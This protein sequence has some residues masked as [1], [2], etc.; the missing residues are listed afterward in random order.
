MLKVGRIDRGTKLSY[1]NDVRYLRYIDACYVR[2]VILASNFVT[3]TKVL[4][5]KIYNIRLY[6]I[7]HTLHC[8][9]NNTFAKFESCFKMVLPFI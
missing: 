8:T 3:V 4:H 6:C 7:L 9:L 1:L 2:L 5:Y